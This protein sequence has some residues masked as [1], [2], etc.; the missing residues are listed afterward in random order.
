MLLWQQ[1]TNY[2]TYS[3]EFLKT[4]SGE[5]FREVFTIEERFNLNS[6]LMLCTKSSLGLLNFTTEFLYSSVVFADIFALLLLVELDEVIHDTLIKIFTTC[7]DT[8]KIWLKFK[9]MNNN[10]LSNFIRRCTTKARIR[11]TVIYQDDE[12]E[13]RR[14]YY[15]F[16]AI[17]IAVIDSNLPRWVSPLV[18]TTSNTPLSMVKRET[19]KVPPPRSN[20]RIFFSPSFLSIP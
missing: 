4:S 19:S 3:V 5:S 2:N 17:F 1:E 13:A 8:K 18:E 9:L 10:K 6:G 15:W 14:K 16:M 11:M 20:T 12:D 7:K